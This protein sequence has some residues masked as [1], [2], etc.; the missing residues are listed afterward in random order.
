MVD[1]GYDISD[2]K[3]IHEE[4]GTMEDFEELIAE[5]NRLGI[6]IILDFVPNHSSDQCEWFKKSAARE[7]GYEDFYIWADGKIN[8]DGEMDPPNNW[9][10]TGFIGSKCHLNSY[11]YLAICILWF[12]LDL[13][14]R[15][16]TILLPS[17]H[18]RTARFE[19]SQWQSS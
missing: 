13:A 2:F 17:V 14:S 3:A 15:K 1:F 5:A 19:L 12:R 18:S 4:Y 16:R 8:E 9:V 10:S 6:K 7:E 11:V